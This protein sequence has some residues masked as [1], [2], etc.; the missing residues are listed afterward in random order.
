MKEDP[1]GYVAGDT[2][3]RVSDDYDVYLWALVLGVSPEDV[4]ETVRKVGSDVRDV[5]AEIEKRKSSGAL[6]AQPVDRVFDAMAAA[7]GA[8]AARAASPD[9]AM[10][11]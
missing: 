7:V 8:C 3:I 10:G 4:H 5:Q 6:S 9:P 11:A 2:R 1:N